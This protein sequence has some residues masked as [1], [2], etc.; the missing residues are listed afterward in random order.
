VPTLRTANRRARRRPYRWSSARTWMRAVWRELEISR[1][2]W[3]AAEQ[4][5]LLEQLWLFAGLSL[6]TKIKDILVI[7][8][9]RAYIDPVKSTEGEA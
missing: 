7:S 8:P 1:R 9:A 6:D 4:R 3:A 2:F 5:H